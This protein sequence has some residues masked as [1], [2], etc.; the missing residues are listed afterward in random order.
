M[1]AK[2]LRDLRES[3]NLQQKDLAKEFDVLESTISM[4][5]N[6]KRVP[7]SDMLIKIAEFFDVTV[8]YLLGFRNSNENISE[9]LLEKKALKKALKKNGFMDN[10]K[11][12]TDE[13]LDKLMKFIIANK[14]FLIDK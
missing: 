8:D 1:F 4:W 14:D 7:Y 13:E 9:E 3:N 10:N 11:D 6:G 2:R 12:L 5:E